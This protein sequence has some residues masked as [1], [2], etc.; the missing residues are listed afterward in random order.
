MS[1]T[2][3]GKAG[4][5]N[6]ERHLRGNCASGPPGTNSPYRGDVST[7]LC[8]TVIHP[9]ARRGVYGSGPAGIT[10][11][12]ADLAD[13]LW[14]L[15][16]LE[17]AKAAGQSDGAYAGARNPFT[18]EDI[19]RHLRGEITLA[20]TVLNYTH[21]LFAVLDVDTLFP[22]LLPKIREL[23]SRIGGQELPDAA[24]ITGGSDEGRGK[25]VICF[26]EPTSASDARKLI[27]DLRR[28]VRANGGVQSLDGAMLTAFPQERSGGIV[29]I[30][31]RNPARHG[32]VDRAFSLDGELGL[33]HVRPITKAN[34]AKIVARS[35]SRRAKW[36]IR[37]LRNPW[38]RSEAIKAH[39]NRMIALARETLRLKRLGEARRAYDEWLERVKANS[40]DLA[41]PSL[42][43]RDPRNV[44]DHGRERTWEIARKRQSSWNPLLVSQADGYPRGVIRLYNALVYLARSHGLRPHL[45]GVDYERIAAAMDC[46]KST[47]WRRVQRAEELG[48][49]V[50][51]DRG[52][53]DSPGKRGK[54]TLM[55]LVCK[56][57][58]QDQCRALGREDE[59][60][61]QRKAM[62][63]ADSKGG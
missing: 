57:Q 55:G 39:F 54:V 43:N 28:R 13:Q 27:Q 18:R 1:E 12:P 32:P 19:E 62:A 21:A 20:F 34:V 29:R 37:Y 41:L 58:T 48:C 46:S 22:Q 56:G 59:R 33:A 7:G 4:L 40:P 45:L 61:R 47:A 60:V 5:D 30:L 26:R 16:H 53:R 2:P 42:R 31:R 8:G 10:V 36:A 3:L 63:H 9:G 6:R 24:F 23:I 49:I 14:R 44:L 38:T 11:P 15:L 17:K 51:Q 52:S 50:L 25:V 35:R